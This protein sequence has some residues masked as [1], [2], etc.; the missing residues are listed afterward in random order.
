MG[1]NVFSDKISGDGLANDQTCSSTG[2]FLGD[3]ACLAGDRSDAGFDRMS[4]LPNTLK[5]HIERKTL[6]RYMGVLG[7]TWLSLV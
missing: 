2:F 7:N 1:D 3:G 4:S 5:I 6:Y